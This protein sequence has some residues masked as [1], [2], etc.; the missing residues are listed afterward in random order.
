MLQDPSLDSAYFIIDAL[1]ECVTDLPKL[2]NFIIQKSSSYPIKWLVSSRNW[3]DIEERLRNAGQNLSLELNAESIATAV[4]YFIRHRVHQLA[5]QKSYTEETQDAVLR[6]LSLNAN[7]T[8]LWV[9]L[10]CQKLEQVSRRKTLAK[11]TDFPP[12]LDDLYGRMVEQIHS[13]DDDDDSTLCKRILATI[14]LAYRPLMLKELASLVETLQDMAND[15]ASL[16][17]IVGLC[18][19]LLTVREDTVYFVHQSAKDYLLSHALDEIYPSGQDAAH[20]SFFLKSLQVMSKTLRRDIYNLEAPGYPIE[21]VRR[22][23]PDPL[24]ASRYSC[25]HWVDHLCDSDV[26]P[27]RHPELFLQCARAIEEFLKDKYLY[28]LEALS[29]CRAVSHGVLSMAR[30]EALFQVL[31]RLL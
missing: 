2:L 31:P 27:I 4:N 1:D 30:L 8:F 15:P 7:D 28:W 23:H 12:G 29:I 20:H 17:E 6:Y 16:Q 24:A 10:V 11:L 13:L 21:K 26:D 14:G 25:F 22:P 18:G 5:R 19:S 3:P 9:A